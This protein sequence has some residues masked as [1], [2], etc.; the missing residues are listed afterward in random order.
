MGFD[1]EW[2]YCFVVIVFK[3]TNLKR[4]SVSSECKH[5]SITN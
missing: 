1:F 4:F 5:L 3:E 2:Q